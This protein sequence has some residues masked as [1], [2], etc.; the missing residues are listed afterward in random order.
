[1]PFLEAVPRENPGVGK[2]ASSSQCS[3]MFSCVLTFSHVLGAFVQCLGNC[4][5]MQGRQLKTAYDAEEL[6]A[7]GGCGTWDDCG[8]W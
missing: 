7:T 1:M 4:N 6:G 3:H 8:R 2:K 5:E